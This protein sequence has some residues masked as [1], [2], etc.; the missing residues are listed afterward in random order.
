MWPTP[1]QDGWNLGSKF[2][3]N[4]TDLYLCFATN[5]RQYVSSD[6]MSEYD[7]LVTKRDRQSNDRIAALEGQIIALSDMLDRMTSR[8]EDLEARSKLDP[9]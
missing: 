9:E 3:V 2:T 4:N 5:A 7:S 8:L 6:E 1:C